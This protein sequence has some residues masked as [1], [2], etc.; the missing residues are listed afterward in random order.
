MKFDFYSFLLIDTNE[1]GDIYE[2][3]DGEGDSD[4]WR[5]ERASFSMEFSTSQ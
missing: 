2:C 5:A 3:G 4:H 1:D